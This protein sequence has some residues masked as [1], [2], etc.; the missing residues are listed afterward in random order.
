MNFLPAPGAMLRSLLWLMMGVR[1]VAADTANWPQWRGPRDSGSTLVS[2]RLPAKL[3]A[4]KV[5]WTAALPGKGCSTPIVWDGRIYLTAPVDGRDTVHAFDVEG[6]PLWQTACSTEDRG[7]HRNASGSNPSPVT[8]GSG[9]FVTVK[10][11]NLAALNLDGTICWQANLVEKFG[12]VNLFWDFGT[13][14]R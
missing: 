2:G 3:D 8:D 5:R 13:R 4:A 11:G 10:R 9:I 7:K 12:R 1:A 6:K 14:R